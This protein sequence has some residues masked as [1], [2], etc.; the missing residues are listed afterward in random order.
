MDTS[1]WLDD[2][3]QRD[4]R[5]Y[6]EGSALLL[7]VRDRELRRRHNLS[8]ADFEILVRL[9]EAPE[10]CM[11]MAEL[12]ELAYYSRS[13]LSHKIAQLEAR[14]LVQRGDD[15]HDKR[16]VVA[17]LTKAGRTVLTEAARDNVQTVREHFIDLLAPSEL[18]T[19]GRAFREV[20]TRIRRSEKPP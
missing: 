9:S 5:A 14:R 16:G 11:R 7:E 1:R 2:A 13:R 18:E 12:A 8:L 15:A 20:T 6:V 3:Q 17:S 19:I 4:W 10:G